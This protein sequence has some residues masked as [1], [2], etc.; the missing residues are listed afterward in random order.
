VSHRNLALILIVAGVAI[1]AASFISN[2]QAT[3]QNVTPDQTT[4]GGIVGP[5]NNLLP[6]PTGYILIIGGGLLLLF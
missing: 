6:V 4:F 1:E 5:I 2:Q 3:L